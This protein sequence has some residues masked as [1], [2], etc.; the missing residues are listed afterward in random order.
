MV[1][2]FAT[3]NRFLSAAGCSLAVVVVL[4]TLPAAT[5]FQKDPPPVKVS[6][7]R[8][9]AMYKVGEEIKFQIESNIDGE[10]TY[11]LSEDGFKQMAKSSEKLVKGKATTITGKLDHPGFLQVRVMVGKQQFLA[12]AAVD[13]TKIEPTAKMP[14]DFDAFWDAGKKELAQVAIDAKLEHIA[15]QSDDRVDCYKISLGNIEGKRVYG[16]LSVP[17]GPGPFPAVLTVPGAGV[18]GIGPDKGHAYLGALSMNI[19]IH[20]IPVDENKDFYDKMSAGPLKDYRDIGMGDKNK[21]Y[22]RAVILGCVRCID[23][24]VT[25]D[26]FNKKELAVT[27]GSQGGALTLITSGLD[28]RVTLAAPNVAAMCDHSGMAFDRVSGWPHWLNRAKNK[29]KV[30]ETSAYFD[31]VNFARKFKGKSVHGVGFIDSVCAPTTVYAAFNVHPEPK[32]MIDS[33]LMGH[34]TDPRW[35]KA[36]EQFFK[37]NMTLKPPTIAQE[38]KQS[39][40][41]GETKAIIG[42]IERLDPRFDKLIPKDAQL[43]KIAEGFIWTEGAVWYKPGKC[44]LFSDIPNNVVIK[45]EP[46]KGVSEYLKP[47]GY[48]GVKPRGG[49]PGDEPGSNG[50]FV[51][52]LGRLHLCEHGDRRVTRIEKDGKKTIL[53]DN[54]MGKKLN[55]PN[56]LA[57]HPN[58][59]VYFTDPP[60]GLA[61]GDKRELDFTGV[62]RISG[63]NG[64][65]SLVSKSLNPN[66][67]AQS[68]DAKKLYVTNGGSWMVFPVNEDGSTG[69]GQVFVNTK[70]WKL[71]QVKGGGLD[72]MKC[73]TH[74]NIFAT[75]PGGVCVIAPDGT[76]LGRFLTGDRTANLCFGGEDGQT[77]FVCVNHRIGMVRTATKGI[78]W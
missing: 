20:D 66:G 49:K 57:L 52:A 61:K 68:P 2:E 73:D 6:C 5:A 47:S 40:A 70:D 62:F 21:S 41:N 33:P 46:G 64:A 56:D 34:G 51:D 16:W 19:I 36:R 10:C 43:E 37:D 11:F 50:L 26:D 7:D 24:L 12:A 8:P 9:E 45:W 77:L 63:K 32:V 17:K 18:Y 14:A 27:G 15:K 23:Y 76:L 38:Q 71:T 78:G 39:T 1:K 3:M 54:Y 22:Y 60:Y 74:G 75:G 72:G 29:D 35:T 13:P 42:T 4:A 44:L 30:L 65:V 25:R 67:I 28:P 48:T 31:A 58:G 53:A 69:E 55:S 59:D